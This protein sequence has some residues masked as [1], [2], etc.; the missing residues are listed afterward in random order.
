MLKGR[1][2]TGLVFFPAF[3][4]AISPSHPEREERLLYTQDQVFEEGL[5]DCEG[6]I[7]YKPGVATAAD[8]N[9][10]HICVPDAL[11]V[12]TESHLISAGGA[13]TAAENVLAG[14]V[15]NAFA[16]VR[17]PGHHAMLVVHGARGFCNVNIEAIMIEYIRNRY[18][19][20]RIA[21]VDT[22]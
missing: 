10:A 16:L 11:S 20:T 7:E 19:P 13:I 18:G 1:R 22:D 14:R 21:V 3:D 9:R 12:V 17:P 4:W 8:I 2:R 15:D 6:I 5:L